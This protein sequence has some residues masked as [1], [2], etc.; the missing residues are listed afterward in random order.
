MDFKPYFSEYEEL[1]KQVEAAF[2]KVKSDY[3]EC[4]KCAVGC[5]DCCHALFDLTLIEALY[6][7]SEFEK[8]YQGGAREKIIERANVSDRQVFRIK[9]QAYKEQQKGR[10]EAEIIEEMSAKRVRCAL[11]NDDNRCDLYE[12]RPITCRLYGIPTQ[13]GE[14]AHSC[15]ISAFEPGKSYPTVKL[16]KIHQRLYEISTA[17]A[18]N[19][20]SKYP[21]LAEMLVPVSMALL[22]DYTD[23]YLGVTKEKANQ[24]EQDS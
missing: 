19:I 12:S 14:K 18:Q 7:K 5:A 10:S 11:L 6:V 16:E 17:L 4:V 24:E 9:R 13:I 3:G 22:T 20:R 8:A 2:N 21:K 1:V 23:D 15:N